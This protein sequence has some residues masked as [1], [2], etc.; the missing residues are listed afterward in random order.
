LQEVVTKAKQPNAITIAVIFLII[1][2]V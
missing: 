1:Y 2:K